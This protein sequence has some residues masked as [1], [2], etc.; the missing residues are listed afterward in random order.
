MPYTKYVQKCCKLL[1]ERKEHPSDILIAPLVELSELTSRVNDFFS[2]DD[3]ECA[4]VGGEM[5][6]SSAVLH[7]RR[8]LDQ[9][10]STIDAAAKN[11][12][13][14][15]MNANLQTAYTENQSICIL[16]Y[17]SFRFGY[18]NVRCMAHSGARRA[19]PIPIRYRQAGQ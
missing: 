4:E 11:N 18:T 12:S 6:L 1:V 9:I 15:K 8:D 2:Y 10:R 13:E 5:M 7:F 14:L 16:P 19:L 17:V 3:I